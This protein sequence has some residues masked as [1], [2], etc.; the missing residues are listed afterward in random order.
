MYIWSP[1][2]T[3]EYLEKATILQALKFY[4]NNK[5]VTARA[6]GCAINTI[7][8]KLEKYAE[9]ERDAKILAEKE[10][11]DREDF[12]RRQRGHVPGTGIGPG[13]GQAQPEIGASAAFTGAHLESVTNAPAK[14]SLSV[15]ERAEIQAVLSGETAGSSNSRP[16]SAVPKT[17]GRA[18]PAVSGGRKGR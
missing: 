18:Q 15:P 14:S 16:G 2:M 3:L 11:R 6:L 5:T 4:Q 9:E 13:T 7:N 10:V 17:D 1:G 8:S 12:N